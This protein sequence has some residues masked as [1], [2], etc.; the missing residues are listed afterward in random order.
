MTIVGVVGDVKHYGLDDQSA[1]QVYVA[2]ARTH[3][4]LPLW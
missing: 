1:S 4:S 3:S 2:Y